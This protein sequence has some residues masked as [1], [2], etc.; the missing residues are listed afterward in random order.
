MLANI[1]STEK[2]KRKA[3]N[4]GPRRAT[5]TRVTAGNT[6]SRD[7]VASRLAGGLAEDT[8]MGEAMLPL[9]SVLQLD[10]FRKTWR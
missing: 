7:V 3:T 8:E 1:C 5:V 10:P 6:P 4:T 9:R 2:D